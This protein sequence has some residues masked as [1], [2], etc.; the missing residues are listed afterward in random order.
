MC[1][2]GVQVKDA[3]VNAILGESLIIFLKRIFDNKA[4]LSGPHN[5]NSD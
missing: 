3:I 5:R 4:F 1:E 2:E